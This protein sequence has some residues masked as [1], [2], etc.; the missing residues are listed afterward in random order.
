MAPTSA[1]G[2]GTSPYTAQLESI[3]PMGTIN[4]KSAVLCAP[5]FP[6]DIKYRAVA[7]TPGNNPINII[8]HQNVAS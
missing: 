5:T 7:N 8:T 6:A 2:V 3:A 1:H 4:I